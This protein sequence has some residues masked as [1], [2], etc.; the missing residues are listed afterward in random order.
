[1]SGT[2]TCAYCGAA[3]YQATCHW[4]SPSKF[5]GPGLRRGTGAG[6][7]WCRDEDS[8]TSRRKNGTYLRMA[9]SRTGRLGHA[10]DGSIRV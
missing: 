6:Y 5:R 4:N 8:C 7:F 9:G 3:E 10:G 2:E 1:M